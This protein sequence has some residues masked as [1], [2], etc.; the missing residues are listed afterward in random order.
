MAATESTVLS[1]TATPTESRAAAESENWRVLRLFNFYRLTIGLIFVGVSLSGADLAPLGSASP[2]LFQLAALIYAGLAVVSTYTIYRRQ[3]DFDS[4]TT[5]FGFADI[6][7]ITVFMHAS[8]GIA[9]GLGLLLLVAVAG[10][11]LMVGKRVAIFYASVGAIAMLLE[12]SWSILPEFLTWALSGDEFS[13]APDL[14]TT[15]PQVGMLGFGLY[16]TAYL[17]YTLATRLRVTEELAE[18]RGADVVK[19]S[20]INELIIQ[21]MQSGVLVCDAAGRIHMINHAAQRFLGLA[22]DQHKNLALSDVTSDL[23]IQLTQWLGSNAVHRTRTMFT[24][25]AGYTLL[26]RFTRLTENRDTEILV[27]LEDMAALRQQAQQLKMAALARLTASI[28]HEIRNPLGALTNA[29]QLLGESAQTNDE[30]KRLVK[31]IDEQGRRMNVI[32]ENVTQLARRDRVNPERIGLGKWIDDFI[33]QYSETAGVP[34]EAFAQYGAD[35]VEVYIDPDQLFQVVSNLGQNGLRHS[36][37]FSGTPLIKLQGGYDTDKRPYLDVIDWG[38]GVPEK[39]R[40]SIF[41]PFFTTTP[42]GTGLGLYIARELCE[43]NGG[44]LTY[45]PG[46]GGVGS[47]FRITFTTAGNGIEIQIP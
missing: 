34:R 13:A 40:E 19:L 39:V 44:A 12:H 3:P 16:V 25:Q 22:S 35:G 28:A 41:D 21:R 31:I 47:R 9:S 45:Y 42:Q 27:F 37:P 1:T 24:S 23:A 14:T 36:A 4:Q 11:S 29:A 17:G 33:R 15:Y 26:P 30:A 32:V 5:V 7:L 8:G 6:T 2:I 46:D 10:N 43:G 18:Q 20:H 38:R